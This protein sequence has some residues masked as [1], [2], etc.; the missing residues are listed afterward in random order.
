M[1][2]LHSKTRIALA[3]LAMAASAGASAAQVGMQVTGISNTFAVYN[4]DASGMGSLTLGASDLANAQAALDDGNGDATKPGGNVELGKFGA[5]PVAVMTG[6]VGGKFITLRSLTK[7]DWQGGLDVDYIQGAAT[8][9]LGVPLTSDQLT[10]VRTAFYVPRAS[11]GGKAPWER[12]SDPNVSYVYLDG[13]TVNIG[14]AGFIDAEPFLE[15]VFGVNL[16]NP[17]PTGGL[18]QASE[19]VEVC[20]GGAGNCKFL[21]GFLA[22]DSLVVGPDGVSF[23]GNFNVQIP[24]PESLALLGIGLVGLFLGRRRRV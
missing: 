21:Y 24:E 10:L 23:T 22:T 1:N 16:P 9:A 18:Y 14:L 11:L 12:L 5:E 6:T 2:L 8:A 3:V 15:G 4:A 17:K 20:L 13:H 7:T 19:V